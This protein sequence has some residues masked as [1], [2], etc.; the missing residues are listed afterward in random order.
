MHRTDGAPPLGGPW[1]AG[2]CSK[3]TDLA[4]MSLP[5]ERKLQELVKAQSSRRGEQDTP[6]ELNGPAL[7]LAGLR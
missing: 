1:A 7:T 4:W 5:E 2:R 6:T 3:G